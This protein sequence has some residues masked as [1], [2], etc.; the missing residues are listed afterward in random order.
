M[1]VNEIKKIT[2]FLTD[3][4]IEKIKQD[5]KSKE[6]IL[7]TEKMNENEMGQVLNTLFA[8]L[9]IEKALE[10]EIEGIE[11]IRA[12]LEQELL[13]CYEI[14][15]AYIA[16]YKKE[17]KKKKK[18]WLLDFLFLSDR[19]HSRKEGI[20]A[21]NKEISSLKNELSN[22]KKQTSNANLGK[23]VK[24]L[25]GSRFS[26]FCELP[27]LCNNPFHHHDCDHGLDRRIDNRRRRQFFENLRNGRID[28]PDVRYTT[29]KPP[30]ETVVESVIVV[31][32]L[33]QP[34][35]ATQKPRSR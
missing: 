17:E 9:V 31:E 15:D 35:D 10:Q 5:I 25:N 18:R 4:D 3:E 27:N 29:V 26:D 11:E 23:V 13:E 14:Y 8:I 7:K 20:G 1:T 32:E 6:S 19:I 33:P 12:E 30:R 24:D 16:K 22:L 28:R 34:S 2:K 21:A